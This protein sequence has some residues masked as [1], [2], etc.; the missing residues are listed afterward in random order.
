MTSFIRHP[1]RASFR[2]SDTRL[3]RHKQ[4]HLQPQRFLFCRHPKPLMQPL[5]RLKPHE[6]GSATTA[7]LPCCPH[8]YID[9]FVYPSLGNALVLVF[10]LHYYV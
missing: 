9:T 5:L 4:Q 10:I 7:T 2:H 1:K 3:T 8:L 6:K